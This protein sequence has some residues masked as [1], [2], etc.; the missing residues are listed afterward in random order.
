MFVYDNTNVKCKQNGNPIIDS[1]IRH[2]SK[3]LIDNETTVFIE[4]SEALFFGSK[5]PYDVFLMQII[6]LSNS[7]EYLGIHLDSGLSF[8]EH[9]DYVVKKY[10]KFCGLIDKVRQLY[11]RKCLL[12][13]YI[14]FAKLVIC[15]GLSVYG[16]GAKRNLKKIETSQRCILRAIFIGKKLDSLADF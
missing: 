1:D 5:Q 4:R 12:M 11:P 7:C 3:R 16:I 6:E 9:F 10:I 2:M 14:S 13:L 8:R 15:C